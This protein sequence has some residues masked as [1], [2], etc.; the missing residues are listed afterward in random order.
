MNNDHHQQQPDAHDYQHAANPQPILGKKQPRFTFNA[1]CKY[2]KTL[3]GFDLSPYNE[4][5]SRNCLAALQFMQGYGKGDT[6]P[7]IDLSR[8]QNSPITALPP[9][10]CT[11]PPYQI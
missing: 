5:I 7:L 9:H 10:N 2:A 6:P 8:Y 1:R 4:T 3:H 11:T